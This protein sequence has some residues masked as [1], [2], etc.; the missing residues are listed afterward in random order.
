MES[1]VVEEADALTDSERRR[2]TLAP[3]RVGPLTRAVYTVTR[4]PKIPRQRAF[5]R[6]VIPLLG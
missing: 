1:G 4:T 2:A 6:L 3:S 5:Q